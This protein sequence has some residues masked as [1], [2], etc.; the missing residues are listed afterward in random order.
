MSLDDW[1]EDG[2]DPATPDVLGL[3]RMRTLVRGLP[4]KFRAVVVLRYQEDMDP[5]EIAAN[6]GWPVN[7]VK[8]RLHRALQML[9]DR[10]ET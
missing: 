3:E 8:S 4:E 7:T 9:K 6:L 5:Q 10:L 2:T 1:V